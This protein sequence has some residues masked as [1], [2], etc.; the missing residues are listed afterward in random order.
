[1]TMTD[2]NE[3]VIA[4]SFATPMEAHLFKS[5]LEAEDIFC[6][7]VNEHLVQA[8]PLWANLVHG[9]QV[10]VRRADLERATQILH[11]DNS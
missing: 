7:I 9:V 6:M 1:M 4:A 10:K 8:N 3:P 2:T 5:R 11:E